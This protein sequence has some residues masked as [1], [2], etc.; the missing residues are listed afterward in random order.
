[1]GA[2]DRDRQPQVKP[3]QY[4]DVFPLEQGFILNPEKNN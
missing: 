4:I 2:S 1:M 3:S